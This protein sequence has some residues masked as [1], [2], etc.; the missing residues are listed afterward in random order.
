MSIL[1]LW[2]ALRH[3]TG[4]ADSLDF[5]WWY[6]LTLILSALEID[7]AIICA[8]IPIFW[9]VI[10]SALPQIF[11]T[12]EVRVTHQYRSSETNTIYEMRRPNS[13]KSNTSQEELTRQQDPQ[14]TNYYGDQFVVNLVKGNVLGTTE[15]V[16][17]K[18]NKRWNS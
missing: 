8:S 13:L 4:D 12:Q 10:V 18:Q 9:P 14:K 7:F 6:P 16:S 15:V 17:G 11:V 5:T 3:P 1:R 2:T